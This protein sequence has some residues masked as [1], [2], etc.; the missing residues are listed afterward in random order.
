MIVKEFIT[1]AQVVKS[2]N[3][4]V[5]GAVRKRTRPLVAGIKEKADILFKE[6]YERAMMQV[7]IGSPRSNTPN[8]NAAKLKEAQEIHDFLKANDKIELVI[9]GAY[10]N[11]PWSIDKAIDTPHK[12]VDGIINEAY[13]AAKS[14][15]LGVIIHTSG[16]TTQNLEAVLVSLFNRW[17]EKIKE[18]IK[19]TVIFEN[20]CSIDIPT[21]FTYPEQIN[22]LMRSVNEINA[23]HG[24]PFNFAF[25]VDTAHLWACGL[26]FTK[27]EDV[28]K[29]FAGIKFDNLFMVHLNDSI[30][31]FGAGIDYHAVITKGNIWKDDRS[32]LKYLVEYCAKNKI[33]TVMELDY[34]FN[35]MIAPL[36][37]L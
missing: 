30:R 6:G 32:G 21:T 10:V 20:H 9:H 18:D 35:E 1:G 31:A 15:A 36:K 14:G 29:W 16:N 3:V 13:L 17:R 2:Y 8:P 26:S 28:K 33:R 12:R 24:N 23:K 34:D 27:A 25:C 7:F 22:E 11:N 19:P 4:V 5:K 37:D